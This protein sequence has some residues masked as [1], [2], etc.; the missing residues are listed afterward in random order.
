MF[1][2]RCRAKA[3]PNGAPMTNASRCDGA[4]M[5]RREIRVSHAEDPKDRLRPAIGL[6]LIRKKRGSSLQV[7]DPHDCDH[8]SI[9]D[10]MLFCVLVASPDEVL[11]GRYG[12]AIL[13]DP[14][15]SFGDMTD[16]RVHHRAIF[17]SLRSR[18]NDDVTH[19]DSLETGDDGWCLATI[20]TH[21]DTRRQRRVL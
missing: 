15:F 11:F 5:E 18:L 19:R 14:K 13:D 16:H 3:V 6:F 7:G 1:D 20:S 2:S 21:H 10:H 8:A 9:I 4:R 12:L 17:S